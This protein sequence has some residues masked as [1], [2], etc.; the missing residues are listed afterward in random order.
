MHVE[1]IT[2]HAITLDPGPHAAMYKLMSDT[3]GITPMV[4]GTGSVLFEA[5]SREVEDA[6]VRIARS[7]H[8]A[9]GNELCVP[10]LSRTRWPRVRAERV[11]ATRGEVSLEDRLHLNV[12]R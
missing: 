1:G 9:G 7:D 6:G 12:G 11:Q 8:A 2:W 10:A 3:F 4:K 5:A